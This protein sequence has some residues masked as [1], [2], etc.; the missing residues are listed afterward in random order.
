[1]WQALEL[2]EEL[3]KV[4][5]GLEERE[6]LA[7]SPAASPS[8][9]SAASPS[10]GSPG[11]VAGM[12]Q[13]FFYDFDYVIFTFFVAKCDKFGRFT[14]CLVSGTGPYGGV[15]CI[16]EAGRGRGDGESQIKGGT[17]VCVCICVCLSRH[18]RRCAFSLYMTH[19]LSLSRPLSHTGTPSRSSRMS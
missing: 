15:G 4:K 7:A 13:A 3:A 8:A 16:A 12:E 2:A 1:M 11:S 5:R 17:E 6:A 10:L 14:M 19:T 18:C 9:P